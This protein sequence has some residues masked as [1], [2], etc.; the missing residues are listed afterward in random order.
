MNSGNSSIGVGNG[1]GVSV[2]GIGIESKLNNNTNTNSNTNNTNDN[3]KHPISYY[4]NIMNLAPRSVIVDII[5][6]IHDC[7]CGCRLYKQN[8]IVN[9]VDSNINTTVS[10][11][12]TTAGTI[13][14]GTNAIDTC[15]TN[16]QQLINLIHIQYKQLLSLIKRMLVVNPNT[17][18]TAM[19]ALN[20]Q[21]CRGNV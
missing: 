2:L 18:I 19:N 11:V 1:V 16:N 12:T 14:T 17:R 6:S 15:T 20:C 4:I 7:D 5:C 13:T 21:L 8:W 3:T 9:G 10:T